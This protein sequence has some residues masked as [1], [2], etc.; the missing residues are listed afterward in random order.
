MVWKHHTSKQEH[1]LT[2]RYSHIQKIDGGWNL[3]EPPKICFHNP[4]YHVIIADST[5]LPHTHTLVSIII[6]TSPQGWTAPLHPTSHSYL[7]EVM[8]FHTASATAHKLM[9]TNTTT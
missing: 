1:I 4:A 8:V 7:L 2:L 5:R 9:N 3:G 6:P